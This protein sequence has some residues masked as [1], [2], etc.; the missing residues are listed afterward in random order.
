M[1][2]SILQHHMVRPASGL[3]TTSSVCDTAVN[4]ICH[5][6]RICFSLLL[7]FTVQPRRHIQ[8][9]CEGYETTP[10]GERRFINSGMP[11]LESDVGAFVL[12]LMSCHRC[13]Q[14][15]PPLPSLSA[16]V[17]QCIPKHTRTLPHFLF[18]C[19]LRSARP[20]H[21]PRRGT[22]DFGVELGVNV[23]GRWT[24]VVERGS[25]LLGIRPLFTVPRLTRAYAILVCF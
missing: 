8:R 12:L 2:S 5:Y 21:R 16:C 25:C 13:L 11:C 14:L 4:V 19:V 17:C 18:A 7:K 9:T 3:P 15:I 24:C 10:A 22:G 6:T 23:H 20:I 1:P